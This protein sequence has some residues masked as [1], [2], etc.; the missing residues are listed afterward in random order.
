MMNSSADQSNN[1]SNEGGFF[2]NL[3]TGASNLWD[4][5][6]D[7]FMGDEETETEET[8]AEPEVTPPSELEQLMAKQYLSPEEIKR[9]RELIDQESDEQR[10]GDLFEALQSKVMYHSQRDN[11]STS[12]GKK[13]GDVMCNLTSLAMVLSYLGVSNPRPEMQFEDALRSNS[14]GEKVAS[15]NFIIGLGWCGER[16]GREI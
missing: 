11:E 14:G 2:E 16:I 3:L 13:I 5:V 9:A 8:S 4:D 12:G 7:F 15:Q 10:R 1:E 6:T